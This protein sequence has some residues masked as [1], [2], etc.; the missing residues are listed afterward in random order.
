MWL[1]ERNQKELKTV[2]LKVYRKDWPHCAQ[3][4]EQTP[5]EKK[6]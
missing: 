1:H 4:V 5:R 3:D 2:L 6:R